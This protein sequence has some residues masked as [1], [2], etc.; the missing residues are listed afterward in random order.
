MNVTEVCSEDTLPLCL[1]IT[2]SP[3][4]DAWGQWLEDNA[5]ELKQ[6]LAQHG[7]L[8]LRGLNISD[9]QTMALFCDKLGSERM[10]Y[11]RGTSPRSEVDDQVYT[12]TEVPANLPLPIHTEMSYTSLYPQALVFCC[13]IPPQQGGETPL[14]DMRKVLQRLPQALVKNFS[15]KGITYHQY[16]PPGRGNTRTKTW[17]DM[18]S[19]EDKQVVAAKCAEQGVSVEWLDR[20]IA[21]LTNNA[22]AIR[23]HPKTG[24]PVWFNQ[25]HVFYPTMSA[26]FLYIGRPWMAKAVRLYEFLLEH[27]ADRMPPYPYGC[28]Y[29]DGS[30][31]DRE[32]ILAIREIIWDETRTFTW[33]RGDVLIVDNLAAG[34]GRLPYRGPRKILAA[35]LKTL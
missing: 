5:S 1:Q 33:Q 11:P 2:D 18:F 17:S 24:Q 29:G 31:I 15:E 16:C 10:D 22:P 27:F 20:D 19:T 7:A 26:E 12:S 3:S 28:S 14:A 32:T 35:L 34:H 4:V 21:K 25:A 23:E 9:A 6:K 8:L 13:E 30:P